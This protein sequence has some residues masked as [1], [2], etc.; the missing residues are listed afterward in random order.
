VVPLAGLE[1]ARV[2][3][4]LILSQA[5]LPVPPQ[6]QVIELSP[7]IPVSVRETGPMVTKMVTS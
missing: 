2:L 3:A 5:R 1:P 4:H 6:G 7:Q